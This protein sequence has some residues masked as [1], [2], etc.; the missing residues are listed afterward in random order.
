MNLIPDSRIF[1]LARTSRCA[2]VASGTTNAAAISRVVSPATNRR[3]SA[4]R[5]SSASAGWQQ[6]KIS[7]SRSSPRVSVI[8]CSP[9]P[10]AG[11]A[12]ATAAVIS[13]SSRGSTLAVR[14][15]PAR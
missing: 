9:S 5:T 10:A 3:V 12:A 14:A 13:P 4:T 1:R 11:S 2:S 7:P 6:A 8:A 15:P